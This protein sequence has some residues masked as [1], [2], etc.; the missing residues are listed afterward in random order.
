MVKC[1]KSEVRRLKTALLRWKKVPEKQR[2]RMKMVL[3]REY[4][5]TQPGIAEAM[6]S[7]LSTVNRAHMAYDE[8]GIKALKPKPNPARKHQ[9]MTVAEE[10]IFLDRFAV[11][12]GAGQML[13][14]HEI[15]AAYE[16]AIGHET[17]NST[18]YALL[19]RHGW[20]KLMPRPYHPKRGTA[21]QNAFKLDKLGEVCERPGQAT[22]T[23]GLAAY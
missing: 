1:S 14:I 3:L 17:S 5:L 4:G 16:K 23:L 9:N 2:E 15:K 20:R 10:K 12:A 13:N 6:G 8:G 21:A 22:P 11:D 7:S 19:D 18:I